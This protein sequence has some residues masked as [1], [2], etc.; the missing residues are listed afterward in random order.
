MSHFKNLGIRRVTWNK[1]H[2]TVPKI[3]GATIKD[4]F[5]LL[6]CT[7]DVWIPVFGCLFLCTLLMCH[8]YCNDLCC[9]EDSE[10][11]WTWWWRKKSLCSFWKSSPDRQTHL[12]SHVL[13][14]KLWRGRPLWEQ[15]VSRSR[16]EAEAGRR[17]LITTPRWG[18]GW[19]GHYISEHYV[20]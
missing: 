6:Y 13:L 12:G 4:S 11:F 9:G 19:G 7:W 5:A 14:S 1:F 8:G 18:L 16:F 10:S 2:A 17:A 15:S 20:T 3:F